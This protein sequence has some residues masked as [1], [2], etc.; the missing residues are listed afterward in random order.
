V[1]PQENLSNRGKKK[2]LGS[3][4]ICVHHD[5]A[6]GEKIREKIDQICSSHRKPRI[7]LKIEAGKNITRKTP[8]G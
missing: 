5:I 6:R 2:I 8:L 3:F 1:K 4:V 7:V